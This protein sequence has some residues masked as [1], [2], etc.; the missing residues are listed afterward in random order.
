MR[1]S[2]V[3]AVYVNDLSNSSLFVCGEIGRLISNFAGR[4]EAEG[5]EEENSGSPSADSPISRIQP[6]LSNGLHTVTQTGDDMEFTT[7]S[8]ES[9]IRL[10]QIKVLSI[11]TGTTFQIG[12]SCSVELSSQLRNIR[13]G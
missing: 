3:E 7:D 13:R 9:V 6:M 10:G 2:S 8:A 1:S 5:T 4:R 12:N 11:A